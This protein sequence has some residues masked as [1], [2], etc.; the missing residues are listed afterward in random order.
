MSDRH[1]DRARCQK[2]RT[3]RSRRRW[4]LRQLIEALRAGILMPI[5]ARGLRGRERVANRW[6]ALP[7]KVGRADVSSAVAAALNASA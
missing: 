5:T 4:R 7:V 3:R 2:N 6:L 1:G